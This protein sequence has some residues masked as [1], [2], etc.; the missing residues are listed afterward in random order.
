MKENETKHERFIR[1][2]EARTNK[3]IDMLKLLGNCSN[4]SNY[5]YTEEDVKKIFTAIDRE[6]RNAKA[7]FNGSESSKEDR[8]TLN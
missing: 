4:T 7:K 8:F 6:V 2:A 1:L 5:R 3:I